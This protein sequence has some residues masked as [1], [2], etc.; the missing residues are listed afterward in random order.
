MNTEDF[1][2]KIAQMLE[3]YQVLGDAHR[4]EDLLIIP[5]IDTI[6]G[7]GA[8]EDLK[9]GGGGATVSPKAIIIINQEQEV[10]FI[11]LN[12]DYSSE[13]FMAE[14]PEILGDL[15]EIIELQ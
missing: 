3:D 10:S 2:L 6:I 12:P 5:V 14:A 8:G 7:F 4:I 13:K 9:A 15:Q 1:K 11:Q